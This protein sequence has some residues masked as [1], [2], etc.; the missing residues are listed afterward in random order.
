MQS[1][2]S[3]AKNP[4]AVLLVAVPIA[5]VRR[6][7][8]P[9]DREDHFPCHRNRD[10]LGQHQSASAGATKPAGHRTADQVCAARGR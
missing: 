8:G 4:M 9:V 10:N 5:G 3:I 1:D 7:P 2:R 6:I